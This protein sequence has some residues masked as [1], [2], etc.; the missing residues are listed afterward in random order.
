MS[1]LLKGLVESAARGAAEEV[2]DEVNAADRAYA[3]RNRMALA[4]AVDRHRM[5]CD[6]GYYDDDTET[7]YPVVWVVL[8][9]GQVSWHITPDLRDELE[10]SRLH[11]QEPVGGYDGHDRDLKNQR[12]VRHALDDKPDRLSSPAVPR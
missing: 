8:P 11:E 10:A 12:I 4:W 6:A 2:A 3:D 5:G 1:D 7:E 9:T